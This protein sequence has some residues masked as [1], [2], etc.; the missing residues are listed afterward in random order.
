M[1]WAEEKTLEDYAYYLALAMT[2][3]TIETTHSRLF[4]E[5]GT[6]VVPSGIFAV[7][8]SAC[9]S[10]KGIN[11][12]EAM[13]QE[14]FQ[15]KPGEVINFTCGLDEQGATDMSKWYKDTH[16]WS[17]SIA[18]RVLYAGTLNKSVATNILGFE[19]GIAGKNGTSIKT[20]YTINNE[21]SLYK[22][23]GYG[24]YFGY[25]GGG[26]GYGYSPVKESHA[27]KL[28]DSYAF[29]TSGGN[30]AGPDGGT[31]STNDTEPGGNGIGISAGG[32]GHG[33]Y[34]GSDQFSSKGGDSGN[35]YKG[36][37]GGYGTNG[38]YLTGRGAAGG[39]GAAGG[40]GAGG[41]EG[42][43]YGSPSGGMVFIEW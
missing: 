43:N 42:Y 31:G 23:G 24:G 11:A 4:T 33:G 25:G 20:Y 41:G 16:I 19:T 6:F 8:I 35:G 26:G 37:E 2:K 40:Y 38:T 17:R 27:G 12:G 21:S 29:S 14:V 5:D 22:Q 36:G 18:E 7:K 1:S 34:Y 3:G 39:G 32:G 10:G 30:G 15:V 28:V 13:L 9:A